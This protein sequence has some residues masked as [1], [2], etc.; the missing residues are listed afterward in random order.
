M[1]SLLLKNKPGSQTKG[2]KYI[3]ILD[4]KVEDLEAEVSKIYKNCKREAHKNY[5]ED[6]L[7]KSLSHE[8]KKRT[9]KFVFDKDES[10]SSDD[11]GEQGQVLDFFN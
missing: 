8:S 10:S 3:A 9:T 2:K 4:K 5:G 6:H 7:E 11:S 1:S